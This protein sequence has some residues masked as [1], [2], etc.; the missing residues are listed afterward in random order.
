MS[1][2]EIIGLRMIFKFHGKFKI[3][4]VNIEYLKIFGDF[5]SSEAYIVTGRYEITENL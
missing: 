1:F 4:Y 5:I 3:D 2:N